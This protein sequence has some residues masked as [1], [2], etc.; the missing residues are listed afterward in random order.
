MNYS[1]FNR[2][3]KELS[4][5]FCLVDMF[6]NHFYFHTINYK[7]VDAKTAHYSKLDKIYKESLLN[8]N[9]V[10]IIFDANFK[11]QVATSILHIQ[12]S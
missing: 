1:F 4:P 9:T 12:K 8:P 2:L 5:E 3:H 11:N 6:P 10:L 7:D